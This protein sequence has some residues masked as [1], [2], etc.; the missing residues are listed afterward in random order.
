M[1]TYTRP[2]TLEQR[3]YVV[4]EEGICPC[5]MKE[6]A[7]KDIDTTFYVCE[8]CM[9]NVVNGDNTDPNINETNAHITGY[10]DG[11]GDVLKSVLTDM[12]DKGDPALSVVRAV[13]AQ[14][15]K[16]KQVKLK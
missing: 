7:W 14:V 13:I 1:D 10:M 3:A 2:L 15:E 6:V 9:A 16:D 4:G 8:D 11:L 12:I 5:C